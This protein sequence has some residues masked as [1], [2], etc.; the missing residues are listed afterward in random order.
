M[1]IA[2]IKQNIST[3]LTEL[4]KRFGYTQSF[5]GQYV[6]FSD[7][8]VSKWENGDSVP[9][10]ATLAAL[11]K[12]YGVTVDFLISEHDDK[13]IGEIAQIEKDKRNSP[14]QITILL[15]S[16]TVVW[17]IATIVFSYTLVFR[18]KALWQIF[19]WAIPS[20]CVLVLYF[21]RHWYRKSKVRLVSLTI[22]SWSLLT[23]IF[24]QFLNYRLWPLFILG[25]PIQIIICLGNSY[26]N[27]MD[28]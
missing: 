21:N 18:P 3:N 27:H 14:T 8:A 25:I 20:C 15:M 1:D 2:N 5:V 17:L 6:N 24:L 13:M 10:L 7:K 23:C 26:M 19:V 22:L 28:R 16:L 11:A 12:L 9:D 4:R